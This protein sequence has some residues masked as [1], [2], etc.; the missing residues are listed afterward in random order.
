MRIF[1]ATLA[2]GLLAVPG[3]AKDESLRLSGESRVAIVRQLSAEFA[4][5]KKTFPAG[6]KSV[7]MEVGKDWNEAQVRQLI[8]NFGTSIRPGDQVQITRITFKDD[9]IIFELNGG[10]KKKRHWYEGI[11]VGMGGPPVSARRPDAETA[12]PPRGSWLTL[13]FPGP[14]PDLTPEQL[15]E[16]LAPVLDFSKQRSATAN[17]VDSL[18][19]E[20]QEAIKARKA[21]LGMDKDMVLAAMGRPDR[22]VREK[23]TEGVEKE[24]WIYGFPPAKT[25]FVSFVGD[26][27][28]QVKEY[29]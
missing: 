25:T 6:K 13:V 16:Y 26:K 15:K 23:D 27:V 1:I 12:G 10:G 21:V 18:P 11:Q 17:W 8:A 9:R 28:V 19:K 14:I 20:F 7:E 29:D 24:D 3:A 22:K 2:I 5:S 4:K